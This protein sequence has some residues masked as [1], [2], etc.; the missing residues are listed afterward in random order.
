MASILPVAG[1]PPTG[2]LASV[3]TH[4]NV[5]AMKQAVSGAFEY[6]KQLCVRLGQTVIWA[7]RVLVDGGAVRASLAIETASGIA[8]AV[9]PD[10]AVDLGRTAALHGRSWWLTIRGAIATAEHQSQIQRLEAEKVQLRAERDQAIAATDALSKHQR[11]SS[12]TLEVEKTRLTRLT[13]E[14]QAELNSLREENNGLKQKL[15]ATTSRAE[16]AESEREELQQQVQILENDK[17]LNPARQALAEALNKLVQAKAVNTNVA[18][19]FDELIQKA[20]EHYAQSKALIEKSSRKLPYQD[21]VEEIVEACK[22]VALTAKLQVDI[23]AILKEHRPEV[24]EELDR[25]LGLTSQS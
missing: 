16:K 23:E 1:S 6:L 7:W 13:T 17:L 24:Y 11:T 22:T 9:L 8:R 12:V 21:L 14:Q 25:S 5:I 18:E 3:T 15:E 19:A 20:Q 4:P 2:F 10:K